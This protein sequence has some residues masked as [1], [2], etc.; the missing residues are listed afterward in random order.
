MATR[1][2]RFVLHVIA[3]LSVLVGVFAAHILLRG[4]LGLYLPDLAICLIGMAFGA[5]VNVAL[6]SKFG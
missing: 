2:R 3:G 6:F 1:R 5:V 4:I